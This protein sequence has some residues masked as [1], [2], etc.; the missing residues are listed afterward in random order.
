MLSAARKFK[1]VGGILKTIL[2]FS[3]ICLKFVGGLCSS[4]TSRQVRSAGCGA[5]EEK[6]MPH[7]SPSR[8]TLSATALGNFRL[9]VQREGREM[10]FLLL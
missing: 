5:Y 3:C 7:A 9:Q 8:V 10:Q 4:K 6:V 1:S 2:F